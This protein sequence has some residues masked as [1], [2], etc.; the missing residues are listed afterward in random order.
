MTNDPYEDKERDIQR[1][2]TAEE[3]IEYIRK[4]EKERNDAVAC[5]EAA[6]IDLGRV[7]A[8]L[9]DAEARERDLRA[10]VEHV[11]Q[12]WGSWESELGTPTADL[13]ADINAALKKGRDRG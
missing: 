5:E 12:V 11:S 3:D 8:Q 4:M 2:L 7:T 13:L 1:G 6:Q 9:I 10:A